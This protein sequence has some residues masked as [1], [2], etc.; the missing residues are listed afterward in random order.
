MSGKN[1][2]INGEPANYQFGTL[3]KNGNGVFSLERNKNIPIGKEYNIV[4]TPTHAVASAYSSTIEVREKSIGT[5]ILTINLETPNPQMGADIINQ[6]MIEYQNES[7]DE[8]KIS[9]EQTI[10]FIDAS[11]KFVTGER[12]S[13]E[14]AIVD[15]RLK[16][17]IIDRE[18]Q[19]GNYFENLNEAD[20][21]IVKQ[22]GYVGIID[23]LDNYLRD[24]NTKYLQVPSSLGIE[25]ATLAALIE[26]FNLTQL[27]RKDLLESNIPRENPLV[28]ETESQIDEIRI[29]LLETLKN[30]KTTFKMSIDDLRRKGS[31]AESQL[32][33]LP[34][35]TK[36]LLAL[37]RQLGSKK[38][39]EEMLL[40][41]RI[42]TSIS[43]ASTIPNSRIIDKA[44]PVTVPI[45]PNRR[46][47]QLL[48]LLIGL[49]LPALFIFILEVINDKISTRFDI[50]KLTNAAILGEVGHSYSEISLVVSKTNRSMVAEQ[51]R[52][53]RSNLQYVL[54]KADKQVILVTSSFSGE[55][56]SFISTNLAG[57]MAVAR[58]KTIILEFDIRK[59]KILSGLNMPKKPGISN[60]LVGKAKMEDLPIP[61]PGHDNLFVLACGPVP[62]NPS[63]LLLESRVDEMF[64]YLKSNFD[65]IIVDTAPVGMVSDAMTL[66]KY[67]DCTL[68]IVRQGYTFKKQVILID[69]FYQQNKLPKISIIIND[70]KMKPGYGYYGYGRYG[71]G[72]GYGY[73]QGYYEEEVKPP[74]SMWARI[75]GLLDVYNWRIN[76]FNRKNK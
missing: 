24:K 6:L 39:I 57:V 54:N 1:F 74:V 35:K 15:Y 72:K 10:N 73:G 26:S 14:N 36:E 71:Y 28:K 56:K 52:I 76:P 49:G 38:A 59:P 16:N 13:L 43:K 4:W 70:V 9:A 51:F 69:E 19:T 25:D 50:E 68:Y 48:A 12:D 45:K 65:V 75:T 41:K 8:K 61:V 37:E 63:E 20:K 58:K 27:K 34:G 67:A 18:I 23:M 5:N 44:M 64:D 2:R 17:K 22:T 42:E 31:S 62:P 55:G 46:A 30:I 7:K 60:F 47:V 29:K 66:S 53:I 3:F 32:N 11:I 21:E 33:Q 40:Q